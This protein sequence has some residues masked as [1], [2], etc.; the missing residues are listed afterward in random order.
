MKTV[1]SVYLDDR[2]LRDFSS[3]RDAKT[4]VADLRLDYAFRDN[5]EI[6]KEIIR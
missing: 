5:F 3:R 4:F 6:R 1:Y 2:L